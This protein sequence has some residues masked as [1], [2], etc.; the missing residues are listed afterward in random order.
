MSN[1]RNAF[2]LIELLVVIAII[3]ILAAILFPVFAQARAKARQASCLSNVKQVTL[4]A[5]QYA[6]DYDEQYPMAYAAYGGTWVNNYYTSY[7]WNAT[8]AGGNCGGAWSAWAPCYFLNAIQPYAKNYQI[9]QCPSA[10]KDN[11][12][13]YAQGAGAPKLEKSS[14]MYNGLLQSYP[15]AGITSSAT[16]PL[17][18]E[19]FGNAYFTGGTL[20]D[21][22]LYCTGSIATACVYQGNK[23][24]CGGYT[25]GNF[26]QYFT[27]TSPM[28]IHGNGQTYGYSDGHAKFRNLSL[29]MRTPG[30]TNYMTEA[31]ANYTVTGAIG[32]GDNRDS[33]G[34]HA[35]L[36]T[37]DGDVQ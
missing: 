7:P 5:T 35:K 37:P 9:G 24:G 2:T 16:V 30:K 3:A 15:L 4:A 26:S 10:V 29:G 12:G 31:W 18:T 25:N 32:D 23:S 22:V 8:C 1:R 17:I 33:F 6:Q 28:G 14:Y 27:T 34:C 19:S 13:G 36:F 20:S 11:L 21:P